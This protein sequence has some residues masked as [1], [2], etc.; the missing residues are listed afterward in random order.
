MAFPQDVLGIRVELL[1]GDTWTSIS[2]PN[3]VMRRDGM[4]GI[5]RGRTDEGGTINPSRCSLSLNNR[6]GRFTSRNPVGPYYGTIGR[7]TQMRVSVPYGATYL[8]MTGFSGEGASAPDSAGI[9]VVG[10]ID[11]RV[12]LSLDS[13]RSN[14]NL[15]GQYAP[16]VDQ[17]SWALQLGR[18]G[19][20]SLAWSTDGTSVTRRFATSTLPVPAPGDKHLA[21]RATLDVNNGASGCTITFYTASTIGG[22]WVQLGD[23]VV[24]AGT[25]SIFNSNTSL[26]VGDVPS[27]FAHVDTLEDAAA[28]VGRVHAFQ[29][30]NGLA[31]SVVANPDFAIPAPGAGS[32]TDSAGVLWSIAQPSELT[33]RRYRFHGEISEWPQRWDTS[34]TDIWTPIEASGILRRLQQGASPIHSSI[35]R[36]ITSPTATDPPLAYWPCEDGS[37]ATSFASALTG[38][39]PMT[40]VGAPTLATDSSFACSE[41]LPTVGSSIW[42][43][44]PPFYTPTG[45]TQVKFLLI[46]PTGGLANNSVIARVFLTGTL[47]RADLVYT[48]ASSGGLEMKAYDDAGT[49]INTTGVNASYNGNRLR[50][51]MQ[52]EE[53]GADVDYAFATTEAGTGDGGSFLQTATSRTAGRVSRVVISPDATISA[54]VVGHVSVHD[55]ITNILDL[56]EEL[57]AYTQETAG[58]RVQRLC[59]EEGIAFRWRGDL[60]DTA[61]MGPQGV[62]TLVSLLQECAEADGGLLYEPRDAFG[63]GYRPRTSMYT[64]DACLTLNYAQNQLFGDLSPTDDDQLVRNDRTYVRTGGSSARYEETTGPL[65]TQA[66][67]DGVGR[68]ADSTTVNIYSDDPLPDMAAWAVHL[69][70]IDEERYPQVTVDLSNPRIAANTALSADV[71]ELDVGDR[72][73][74]TNPPAW[75]PP[76]QIEQVA[77]GFNETL[78]NKEYSVT[79]NCSPASPWNVTFL[80]NSGPYGRADTDG[81]V[82][83]EDLTTT[84]TDMDVSITDGPLWVTTAG[85][86][87][88]FPFDVTCAGERMTVTACTSSALDAFGRT[89][90]SGWGSADIGG[91]YTLFGGVAGDFTVTG[92]TGRISITAINSSR[93]ALIPAAA[94]NVDLRAQFQTPA[95]ATGGPQYGGIVAR[96]LGGN[97]HYYARLSFNTNQTV[98]LVLQ[99]RLASVQTDLATVVVPGLTH[100]ANTPV[101]VR[102][103][104]FGS[105]LQAR[106]WLV[107]APEPAW[108]HAEASDSTLPAAGSIGVR[109]ILDGANTNTLPFLVQF[110][111]VEVL[112][113]QRFTVTRSVNGVVKAQSAAADVRLAQP[114]ILGL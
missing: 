36:G 30:R 52:F 84:E 98:T 35:Y 110:D 51:S 71:Q 21:V 47:A 57:S 69:G 93:I 114:M 7:N 60:D 62:T 48:T 80:D 2:S 96:A 10:D 77:Q 16:A 87:A 31:G 101:I 5:S 29:L 94:A 85:Q 42:T 88:E 73:I 102:L 34:G 27:L 89:S 100:A 92:G 79:A 113:P 6:D 28:C 20:L 49:L 11:I 24:Q 14:Q 53:N 17:R 43:G 105:S 90:A 83:A 40:W 54:A 86:P 81:T 41:P 67:P 12:D 108:W 45:Q 59:R 76:G 44:R 3:Y 61:E 65:S 19:R 74:I 55:I 99:R 13:W 25:T 104:V 33:D 111:N 26:T 103:R 56:T 91:A 64:Q 37:T 15:C 4:I 72:I 112:N 107:G 9:S 22:T 18:D 78:G 95:L 8:R 63:L 75:L 97:D 106:A 50:V 68:Y 109:T 46:I 23:P 66:P 38:G 58:R 32:F 1:L 70:T 82:L 39:T